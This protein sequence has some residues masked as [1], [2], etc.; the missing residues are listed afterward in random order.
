MRCLSKR[1]GFDSTAIRLLIK[2]H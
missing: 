1:F 2:G